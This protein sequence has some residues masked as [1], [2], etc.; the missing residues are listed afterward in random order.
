MVKGSCI[1]FSLDPRSHAPVISF[2]K[3]LPPCLQK[4]SAGQALLG[5]APVWIS[6]II[7]L[8]IGWIVGI[9]CAAGQYIACR[10]AELTT[11]VFNIVTKYHVLC[12]Q[13]GSY[14][15]SVRCHATTALSHSLM[16]SARQANCVCAALHNNAQQQGNNAAP[17]APWTHQPRQPCSSIWLRPAGKGNK[18]K[19]QC[20]AMHASAAA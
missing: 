1:M 18:M 13:H 5:A 19:G 9:A 11:V 10:P 20:C 6:S 14:T 3:L 15:A 4:C 12:L 8:L 7:L 2:C 17:A 16:Q